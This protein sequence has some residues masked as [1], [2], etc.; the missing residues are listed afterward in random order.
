[1]YRDDHEVA[2]GEIV[3]TDIQF[4]ERLLQSA[5][6]LLGLLLLALEDAPG[7]VG[8]AEVADGVADG[9]EVPETVEV[10]AVEGGCV[11]KRYRCRVETRGGVT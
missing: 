4:G 2:F 6:L 9:D 3:Q 10:L 8:P 11:R 5:A 1:M 7:D